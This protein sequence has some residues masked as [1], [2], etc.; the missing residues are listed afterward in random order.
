MHCS[1]VNCYRSLMVIIC[2]CF[3]F[4]D[5]YRRDKLARDMPDIYILTLR[6]CT[7]SGSCHSNLSQL[8][9]DFYLYIHTCISYNTGKSA[10]SDI[11]AR[12]PRASAYL[13]GKAQRPVI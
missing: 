4:V 7:L 10:L 11:Y 9:Y 5:T 1:S 3:K 13:S 8:Y 6:H 2:I 12:H